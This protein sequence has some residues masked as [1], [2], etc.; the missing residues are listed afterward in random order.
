MKTLEMLLFVAS[1]TLAGWAAYTL[2]IGLVEGVLC[3]KSRCTSLGDVAGQFGGYAF[4]YG[5]FV[6]FG[7]ASAWRSY[8]N[9]GKVWAATSEGPRS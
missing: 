8:R 3:F 4:V 5:N 1:L 2:A 9:L 7:L 6:A